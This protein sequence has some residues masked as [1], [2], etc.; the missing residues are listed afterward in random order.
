MVFVSVPRERST[1]LAEH[2]NQRK[3]L[4][5]PGPRMRLVTHLDVDEGGIDRALGA[6]GEFFGDKRAR[7]TG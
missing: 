3:V 6:F 1:A 5:L 4:T 2:L 7:K